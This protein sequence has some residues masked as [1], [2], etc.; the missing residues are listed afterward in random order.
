M[1][2]SISLAENNE[3]NPVQNISTIYTWISNNR[4]PPRN[5][6]PK[7]AKAIYDLRDID[8]FNSHFEKIATI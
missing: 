4:K 5:M 3:F 8:K 7:I 6:N 1:L 2:T